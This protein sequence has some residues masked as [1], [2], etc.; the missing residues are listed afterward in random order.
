MS[1]N[2][3]ITKVYI[4]DSYIGTITLRDGTEHHI[5]QNRYYNC[6]MTI[7]GKEYKGSTFW[8]VFDN[9]CEDDIYNNLINEYLN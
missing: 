4:A 1:T 8:K 9:Y 2:T 5:Y 3:P 7:H 6:Y